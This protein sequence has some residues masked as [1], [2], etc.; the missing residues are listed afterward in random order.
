MTQSS[1]LQRPAFHYETSEGVTER[2]A[3]PGVKYNNSIRIDSL[4]SNLASGETEA[5]SYNCT[6]NQVLQGPTVPSNGTINHMTSQRMCSPSL[7]PTSSAS[8]EFHLSQG[9]STVPEQSF[10]AMHP[11][12]R[13][14]TSSFS[15]QRAANHPQRNQQLA[16]DGIHQAQHSSVSDRRA[17][18]VAL[19]LH[20]ESNDLRRRC[21]SLEYQLQSQSAQMQQLQRSNQNVV[22]LGVEWNRFHHGE[23]RRLAN[24]YRQ[25]LVSQE[26]KWKNKAREYQD[27][28][29][30]MRMENMNLRAQCAEILKR[31]GKHFCLYCGMN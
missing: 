27:R 22:K 18:Q 8:S 2:H 5:T 28:C 19:L 6:P 7:L 20:R 1:S 26:V 16:R 4:M 12:Q 11:L 23:M 15:Q 24:T 14:L 13:D 25:L 3:M 21:S 17:S 31:N 10:A 9:S 29:F 30:I